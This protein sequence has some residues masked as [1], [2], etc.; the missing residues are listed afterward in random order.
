MDL[1]ELY[2]KES[3]EFERV[4]LKG[5]GPTILFWAII[6]MGFGIFSS[7]HRYSF[8]GIAGVLFLT[9]WPAWRW[10]AKKLRDKVEGK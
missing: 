6:S 5:I 3:T 9:S 4:F 2:Q 8:L 10:A 7:G 1:K